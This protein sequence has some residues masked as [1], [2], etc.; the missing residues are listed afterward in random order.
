MQSTHRPVCP[1][2]S[3]HRL[4]SELALLSGLARI[5]QEA[6]EAAPVGVAPPDTVSHALALIRERADILANEMDAR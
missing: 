5:A 2:S 6:L 4:H 1:A 3:F